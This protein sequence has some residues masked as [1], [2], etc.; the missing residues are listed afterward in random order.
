[1]GLEPYVLRY[2][3]EDVQVVRLDPWTLV[4]PVSSPRSDPWGSGSGRGQP[5]VEWRDVVSDVQADTD[6][7][8]PERVSLRLQVRETTVPDVDGLLEEWDAPPL[9]KTP[10]PGRSRGWGVPLRATSIKLCTN[11]HLSEM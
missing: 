3:V 4:V 7:G 1:M 8:R 10:R 5:G 2:P 9:S 11:P 6:P